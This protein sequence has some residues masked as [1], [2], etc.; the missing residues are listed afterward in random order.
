MIGSTLS[1]LQSLYAAEG[2]AGLYKGFCPGL[3]GVVHGAIQFMTYEELKYCY[4]N[5]KKKVGSNIY[6]FTNI[7]NNVTCSP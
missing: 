1:T 7:A 2:V 5:Y 6:V 3:F 4:N